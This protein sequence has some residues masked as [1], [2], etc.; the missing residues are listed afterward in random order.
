MNNFQNHAL[1]IL[2]EA[3]EAGKKALEECNP[4]PMVVEEHMDMFNDNSPV[5]QSWHVSDGVCG[6]AWIN[7]KAKSGSNRRF[8]N[9]LKLLKIASNNINDFTSTVLFKKDSYYGGFTYWV[10]DGG[11]SMQRKEDFAHAF[12]AV[13]KEHDID[14]RVMSRID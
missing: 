8:I 6:F 4:Q 1:V 7:I 11:Q 5:K 13:L 9:E 2:N 10:H 14:C 12:A 3:E